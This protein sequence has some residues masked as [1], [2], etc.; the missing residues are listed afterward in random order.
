MSRSYRKTPIF[1]FCG[2][3]E[4]FDKRQWHKR[5]RTH[6]RNQ[7]ATITQANCDI[8]PIHYRKV[9]NPWSMAKDGKHWFSPAN[10]REVARSI[11]HRRAAKRPLTEVLALQVRLVA[12]WQCK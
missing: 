10:Q 1:A 2:N 12:K 9:S 7:L 3:S 6:Q 11:A 4:A 8:V 5:W